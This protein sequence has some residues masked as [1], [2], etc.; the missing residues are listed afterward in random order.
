M[1]KPLAEA[2]TWIFEYAPSAY[3]QFGY[4]TQDLLDLLHQYEYQ[5]YRYS[6][7]TGEIADFSSDVP[8]SGIVN[9]IAAKDKASSPARPACL[10][11]CIRYCD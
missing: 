7:T 8:P 2:P 10:I 1:A 5:V 3:A 9:L 4:Q 6:H 11:V